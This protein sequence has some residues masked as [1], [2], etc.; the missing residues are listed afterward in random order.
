MVISCWSLL[1]VSS[2]FVP[3]LKHPPLVAAKSTETEPWVPNAWRDCG[4][5]E[6]SGSQLM[7]FRSARMGARTGELT[8]LSFGSLRNSGLGNLLPHWSWPYGCGHGAPSCLREWDCASPLDLLHLRLPATSVSLGL[9]P[10]QDV[11]SEGPFY[12][13]QSS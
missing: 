12:V 4:Q 10:L 13:A 1:H 3:C 9:F 6:G 8:L 7:L 2:S 11:K 5:Q